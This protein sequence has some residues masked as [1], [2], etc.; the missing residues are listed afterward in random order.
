M[1]ELLPNLMLKVNTYYLIIK[2]LR[3]FVVVRHVI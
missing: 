3:L 2:T 1:Y